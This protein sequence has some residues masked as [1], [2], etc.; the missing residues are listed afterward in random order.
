[1]LAH[2]VN[3]WCYFDLNQ[4]RPQKNHL[5]NI[6]NPMSRLKF[7]AEHNGILEKNQKN[8]NKPKT[9]ENGGKICKKLI[10][11][12]VSTLIKMLKITKKISL[13]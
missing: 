7:S 3:C 4:C 2:L 6:Q 8:H 5:K 11:F 1:M 13:P 9:G 10:F 12:F